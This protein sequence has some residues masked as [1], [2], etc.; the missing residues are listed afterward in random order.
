MQIEIW[1]SNVVWLGGIQVVEVLHFLKVLIET[2]CG[3][4][5]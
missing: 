2:M 5:V 4:V 3:T 1:V